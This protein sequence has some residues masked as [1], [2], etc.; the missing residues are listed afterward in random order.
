MTSF[1]RETDRNFTAAK[2]RPPTCTGVG[3]VIPPCLSGVN[4]Q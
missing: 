2:T 4:H 3:T 1:A